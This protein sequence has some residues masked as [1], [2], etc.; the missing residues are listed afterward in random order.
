MRMAAF[1]RPDD[2]VAA[3]LGERLRRV[4]ASAGLEVSSDC[5]LMRWH[6]TDFTLR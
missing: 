2:R 1:G 4:D 3:A 5:E 6:A